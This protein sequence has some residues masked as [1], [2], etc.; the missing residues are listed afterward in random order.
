[1]ET[2][3]KLTKAEIAKE[4]M[5]IYGLDHI[6]ATKVIDTVF[7]TISDA[8]IAGRTT[9]LRGFGTFETRLRKGREVARN[10]K[11][12][13]KVSVEPHLVAAFRPGQR[14]KNELW[15]RKPIE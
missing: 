3:T 9:E 13:E 5:N 10:P 1:M 2:N 8:L 4:I 11:S 15:E 12:G 14:L 6:T 7:D